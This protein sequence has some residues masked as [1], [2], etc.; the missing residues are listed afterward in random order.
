MDHY[1]QVKRVQFIRKEIKTAT[2]EAHPSIVKRKI[3][4]TK[5][6]RPIIIIIKK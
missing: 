6:K 4:V 3:H 1:C 2:Y 5:R